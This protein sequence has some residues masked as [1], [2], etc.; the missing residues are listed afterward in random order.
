VE[1]APPLVTLSMERPA[2][3]QGGNTQLFCKVTVPAPFAEKAKVRLIGLPSKVTTQELEITKDT[4]EF[5]F[6]ITADKTSPVGQHNVF[7]QVII[8]RGGELILGNTG[9]TQ[10]RID[11]PLPP[12]VAVT[13]PVPPKVDPKQPNPPTPPVPEKRLTRLEQLRKEA[14]EREKAAANG[15]TPAP[16]KDEPPKKP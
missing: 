15:G 1:V 6:P 4:K 8:D 12:K 7:A 3:E 10:L 16:K 2:V 14:E 11:V 9:G 5:A 13:P